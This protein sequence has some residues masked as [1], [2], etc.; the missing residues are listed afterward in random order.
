[1]S[2]GPKGARYNRGGAPRHRSAGEGSGAVNRYTMM[3][4]KD[5]FDLMNIAFD[6]ED[7]RVDKNL[8]MII[9]KKD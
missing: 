7:Y 4:I 3:E 2:G 8:N 5:R 9:P 1:M 6:Q